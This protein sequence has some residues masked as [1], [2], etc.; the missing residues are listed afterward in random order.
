MDLRPFVEKLDS[1]GEI[2]RIEGAD[3]DLEIGTLTEL[4][5]DKDGPALLFDPVKGYPGGFG[6][7][8]NLIATP[9]RLAV[10]LGFPEDIARVELVR[11]IKDKFRQVRP[12]KPVFVSEGPVLDNVDEGEKI[13][14]FKFPAP[15]WHEDDGG[16]YLGTGDMVIMRHPKEGWVNVGT[17]RVQLHDR[18]TLGLY[19]DPGKQGRIIRETYWK[20]GRPCPVAVV[21][22]AHPLVWMP[23]FLALPWGTSEYDI[24]GGLLGEPLQLITGKYT[25]LPIPAHAEIAVE[26]ECP[27]PQ[28]ESK[29]EGPFG[30]TTG[31]YGS[32]VRPEAV[33]KVKRVMYRNRPLINGAPPL[34]PPANPIAGYIMRASNL[35]SEL[36]RLGLP[37]IKGV[38]FMRA[39]GSRYISVVSI[40]QKYAGHAKQ[41]GMATMSGAEGAYNGRF[42]IVVDDDI[43]PSNDD[44]VI[45]AVATRCDPA[46]SVDVITNCWSSPLD[47]TISP[48]R[49]ARGDLTNSRAVVV[50]C[51][52]YHW[53]KDFAKVNRA[54]NQLREAAEKKWG[55]LIRSREDGGAAHS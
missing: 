28:V 38:W 22:A 54:S 13:D 1:L 24:A 15:K 44:D 43:D 39:G 30:E 35:W 53:R 6:V 46:T 8:S 20:E 29:E 49:R 41:V 19:I 45:W 34:K 36:E 2:A 26:G 7:I 27:P 9:R 52:P 14:L 31:Y 4:S 47:P 33:I 10:A 5:G 42:N 18:H 16:R 32:G 51:R 11:Q 50:A 55:H 25:G 17:Y 21:I 48:E 37:G 40:E 23:A 12:V 3:W